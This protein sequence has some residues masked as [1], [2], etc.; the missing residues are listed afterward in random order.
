MSTPVV[1]LFAQVDHGPT[2]ILVAM[3]REVFVHLA[4]QTRVVS[5]AIEVGI[6]SL[7]CSNAAGRRN[8]EVV[9]E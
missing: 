3:F 8:E 7:Q 6:H 1:P 2:E 5:M 4:N 9:F